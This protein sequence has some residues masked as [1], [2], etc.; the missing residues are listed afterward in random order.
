MTTFTPLW[1]RVE[2]LILQAQSG[3]LPRPSQNS[4][5]GNL[6]N[7]YRNEEHTGLFATHPDGESEP[8]HFTTVRPVVTVLATI[9]GAA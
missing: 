7:P 3:P 6:R 1:P 2:P 5:I 4:W 9:G 8:S